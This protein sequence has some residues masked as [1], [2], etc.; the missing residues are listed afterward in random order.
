MSHVPVCF[1]RLA[2][3]REDLF[4]LYP[5]PTVPHP[6]PP[7]FLTHLP[8]KRLVLSRRPSFRCKGLWRLIR[9]AVLVGGDRS[10]PR[11]S[12]IATMSQKV[13]MNSDSLPWGQ[14]WVLPLLSAPPS[15]FSFPALRQSYGFWVSPIVVFF[16]F[17]YQSILFYTFLPLFLCNFLPLL[18]LV[19]FSDT[20]IISRLLI[21]HLFHKRNELH[22]PWP[23]LSIF[24]SLWAYAEALFK[25][26]SVHWALIKPEKVENPPQK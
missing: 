23:S 21:S 1:P 2:C 17:Y 9:T 12:E 22:C 19:S 15:P 4:W 5:A 25:T 20:G 24:C 18:L 11:L 6:H 13:E 8:H 14:Y 26:A 10:F 3:M 16:G 7:C